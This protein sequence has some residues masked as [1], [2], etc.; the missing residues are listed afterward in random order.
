M[1]KIKQSFHLS[2]PTLSLNSAKPLELSPVLDDVDELT[3]SVQADM[4]DHDD[5]WSLDERP[6]ESELD[7]FWSSVEKDIQNDPTWIS[8]DD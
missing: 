6:D 4:I 1:L 7:A 2:L 5:N 3:Q 8:F